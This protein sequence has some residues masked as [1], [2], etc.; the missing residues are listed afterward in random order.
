MTDN[1][2]IDRLSKLK[3]PNQ[4]I[5]EKF[6]LSAFSRYPTAEER[7]RILESFGAD[8]GDRN[9]SWRTCFGRS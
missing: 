6:H 9:R 8:G 5:V 2:V 4:A 1:N 7:G 3:L